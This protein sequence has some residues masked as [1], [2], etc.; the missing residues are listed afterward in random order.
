ML[1][2]DD[3]RTVHICNCMSANGQ[4]DI[5]NQ[6]QAKRA[7]RRYSWLPSMPW[8]GESMTSMPR[9]ALLERH[10]R[11]RSMAAWRASG[12]RTMPPLPMFSRPASNWGLMRMTA[13]PCQR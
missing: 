12:S 10:R 2:E 8:M 6:P 11:T 7:W 4:P 3:R 5:D 9:A 13:S 1:P